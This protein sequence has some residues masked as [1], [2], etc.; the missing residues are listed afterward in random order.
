MG[1]DR[2]CRLVSDTLQHGPCSGALSL[3]IIRRR[4]RMHDSYWGGD[5]LANWYRRLG[6]GT[7]KS[8]S[9]SI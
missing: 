1:S 9:R 2:L 4:A 7:F 6:Q 8:P 5:G 3:F